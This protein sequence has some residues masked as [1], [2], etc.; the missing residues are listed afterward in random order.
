MKK[1]IKTKSSDALKELKKLKE[2][3]ELLLYFYKES[4]QQR[5]REGLKF[6]NKKLKRK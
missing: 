1:M 6:A 4:Y 5:G 2:L 3:K